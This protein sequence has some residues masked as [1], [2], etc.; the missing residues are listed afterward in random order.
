[1][2]KDF[3]TLLSDG[4]PILLDGGIGTELYDKGVFI[5]QCFDYVN[6]SNPEWVKQVHESYLAAGSDVIET[7]TFGANF[8]RLK[9]FGLEGDL[10][11]INREGV[12]LAREVAGDNKYVAGSMGPLGIKIE[13]YGPTSFEETRAI[14]RQ[15]AQVLEEEGV[16]LYILETFSRMAELSE[17]VAGVREVSDKA[18][19]ALLTV[20]DH[21]QTLYGTDPVYLVPELE[22]LDIDVVGLNCSVGPRLIYDA[23]EKMVKY[24][25]KPVCAM[26]NAG[27]PKSIDGRNIYLCTPEYM[28]TYAKRF[29]KLGVRVIGGCC[30][31][32]PEHIKSIAR[33][34]GQSMSSDVKK[35]VV[36]PGAPMEQVEAREVLPLAQRSRL[37]EKLAAG[38]F[39][40]SVE[41]VPP[42]G[43]DPTR[44]L[45][46]I[47]KLK[48]AEIDAVNIPD[49]PRASSRMS[50][51]ILAILVE[52]QIGIETILHY[53]CRD[54][55]ILGMQSDLLGGFAAGLHNILAVTGDPPKLGDYPDATAVFDIDAIGL[56]NIINHLNLGRDIGGNDLSKPTAYATGVA[57][58]PTALNAV[59]E[60]NRFHWKVKAGADFA[61]TQPVFDT[62]QFLHFYEQVKHHQIPIIAG[63][64]PLVSYKNAEFMNN[65]V[66]GIS[67]P[68]STLARMRATASSEEAKEVGL[69][70]ALENV[71]Q[72]LPYIAGAQISAPMGNVKF[73]LRVVEGV[74]AMLKD[75]RPAAEAVPVPS[76]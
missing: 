53:C 3:R 39:V 30:G 36:A 25:S 45:K 1:M 56:T 68:E 43:C 22:K 15:Q 47:Q 4:K 54:R 33:A 9:H 70:I 62:A 52:N 65:E 76:R 51:Q 72:I 67:I 14:Y 5:N 18:I 59:E 55:N 27:N 58:N 24:S 46:R 75:R 26:P 32:S 10:E 74:R 49:G 17:A 44:T 40:F 42:K 48:D 71:T 12:R 20:N 29:L 61:I 34:V 37:G 66:P 63:I 16:D 41:V 60:I 13:P 73:A 50:P 21:G 57:L 23:L 28:A 69:Q 35:K 64:W 38:A 2:R 7:N 19:I 6:I 8:M 31:T 11:S